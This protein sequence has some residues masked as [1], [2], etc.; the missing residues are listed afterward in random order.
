MTKFPK[1]KPNDVDIFYAYSIADV[2]KVLQ[3]SEST[4][5]NRVKDGLIKQKIYP[6]GEKR[7]PGKE[8][9]RFVKLYAC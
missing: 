3:V 8:L 5:R 7:I 4:V 2:A 9:R 6:T 1:I